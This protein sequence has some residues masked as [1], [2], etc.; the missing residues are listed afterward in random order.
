MKHNWTWTDL[1]PGRE[2]IT[3]NGNVGRIIGRTKD[4]LIV[5]FATYKTIESKD[6]CMEDNFQLLEEVQ[7]YE[8]V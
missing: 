5:K 2:I 4:E 8:E 3:H 1:V 7:T 6:A